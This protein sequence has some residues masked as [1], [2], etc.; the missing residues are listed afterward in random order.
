MY[1][2]ALIMSLLAGLFVLSIAST[3]DSIEA[4]QRVYVSSLAENVSIYQGF[5]KQYVSANPG[6][7]GSVSDASLG[8]PSWYGK[9]EDMA[10]YVA[11]GKAYVYLVGSSAGRFAESA[12]Y[13]R[14]RTKLGT[15]GTKKGGQVL[16]ADAQLLSVPAQ[17]PEGAFVFVL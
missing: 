11:S 2:I 3:N 8:L 12:G 17:I 13:M 16:T 10:L 5:A 15:W 9:Q 14:D 1:G 7:S 6:F 4:E